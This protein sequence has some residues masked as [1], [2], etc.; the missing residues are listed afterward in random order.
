MALA[1]LGRL[2]IEHFIQ[3]KEIQMSCY[4]T[5]LH[6]PCSEEFWERF[7][8]SDELWENFEENAI[9]LMPFYQNGPE[10]YPVWLFP[11]KLNFELSPITIFYGGNGSGKSTILNIIA[12]KLGI[13]HRADINSS[14][15]FRLFSQICEITTHSDFDEINRRC[16]I[17]TSDDVFQHCFNLRSKN[18]EITAKQR[19]LI[20]RKRHL[21]FEN[22]HGLDDLERY[23]RD[24]SLKDNTYSANLAKY[25]G[26]TL[27]PSS[28][29]ETAL[30]YFTSAIDSAGVYL[31]DEPENSMSPMFQL[32]LIEFLQTTASFLGM[33]FIIATHSPLILGMKNAVIFNLD[34]EGAPRSKW[35]ELENIRVLQQFFSE[36][37]NEFEA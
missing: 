13:G 11:R 8:P 29:G 17:I 30:N 16:D 31:L 19:E 1:L 12:A 25:V 23:K 14:E 34:E 27:K 36:R 18:K 2:E 20:R 9:A 32:K 37:A 6:I 26:H 7:K 21:A 22:L 28:N 33:Q 5:S 3:G 15:Y 24:L 10:N 35:S 4:I